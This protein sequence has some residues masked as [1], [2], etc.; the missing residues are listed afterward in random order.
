[1]INDHFDQMIKYKLY[2][3]FE[4]CYIAKGV[5]GLHK[6]RFR[7]ILFSVYSFSVLVKLIMTHTC[8]HE[9]ILL[10]FSLRYY[11][12]AIQIKMII[13]YK[14]SNLFLNKQKS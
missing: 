14:D 5:N 3:I 9:A 6:N 12:T 2:T 13:N 10:I 8:L 7:K 11:K 4:R 1:M